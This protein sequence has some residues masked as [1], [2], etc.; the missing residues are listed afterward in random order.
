MNG[1][2]PHVDGCRCFALVDIIDGK[3][4]VM[5]VLAQGTDLE[6]L[7]LVETDFEQSAKR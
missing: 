5:R 2:L 1:V 6:A 3:D 7:K 4:R